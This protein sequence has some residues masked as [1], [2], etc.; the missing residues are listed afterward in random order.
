MN[1]TG[2]FNGNPTM[3]RPFATVAESTDMKAKRNEIARKVMSLASNQQLRD[4]LQDLCDNG[5]MQTL[6]IIMK[7]V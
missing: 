3:N 6:D 2:D 4:L 7:Y 5:D 1:N